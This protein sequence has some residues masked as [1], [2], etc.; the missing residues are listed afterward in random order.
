M[1]AK[2]DAAS[3][4]A[5][6]KLMDV[7]KKKT[8]QLKKKSKE[9]AALK[10]TLLEVEKAQRELFHDKKIVPSRE[11]KK[12]EAKKQKQDHHSVH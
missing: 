9:E 7:L 8:T 2:R 10:K 3:K 4:G 12:K 5:T 1:A 11:I 6:K